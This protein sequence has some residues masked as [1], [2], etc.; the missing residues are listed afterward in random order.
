MG[1]LYAK[2]G[3]WQQAFEKLSEYHKGLGEDKL[4]ERLD[5]E[6]ILNV[7]VLPKLIGEEKKKEGSE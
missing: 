4:D 7:Q 2:L 3:R 5:I 1:L 6:E